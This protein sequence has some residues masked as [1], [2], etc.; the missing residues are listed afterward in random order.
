[1]GKMKEVFM[2]MREEQWM[3]CEKEYLRQYAEKLRDKDIYMNM[4]CPNCYDKKLLYNSTADINCASC[5]Q[6]FVLVD[7]NTLRYA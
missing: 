7:A 3:G 2:Q 1:M 6:K 4:P 5:A